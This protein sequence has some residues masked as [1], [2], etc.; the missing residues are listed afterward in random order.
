[1][2][3]HTSFPSIDNS[4][5]TSLDADFIGSEVRRTLFAMGNFKSP[6]P[7]GL[8]PLFFKSKWEVLGPI[9]IKFVRACYANPEMIHAVN[10]YL[11]TRIPKSVEPVSAS[12]FRPIALCNAIYEA[13]TKAITNKI[14]R[15]M[16]SL[17]SKRQSSFIPGRSTNDNIIF[18][19]E[20]IHSMNLMKCKEGFMIVKLDLQK[21]YDCI[22]WRFVRETLELIGQPE[23]LIDLIMNCIS[24]SRMQ[25]NWNERPSTAF[26]PSHGLRQGDPLSPYLFV[27]CKE[28][29]SHAISDAVNDG[30]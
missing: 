4:A 8:H 13:V 12:E 17:V 9:F 10:S 2:S 21:A 24:S 18:L 1:M 15:I 30:D 28:Q 6:G 11:A 26:S 20:T 22:E 7:D 16:P 23:N 29:L 14:R 25:M 19:Q 5:L 3:T 27:L